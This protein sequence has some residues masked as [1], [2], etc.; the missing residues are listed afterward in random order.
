[1]SKRITIAAISALA[2]LA[3]LIPAGSAQAAF[4]SAPFCGSLNPG[5]GYSPMTLKS[6]QAC[7]FYP[8]AVRYAIAT[9]DVVQGGSGSV[10]LGVVQYPPGYPKGRTLSPTGSGP[11]NYW[12]C[13]PVNGSGG[14][15]YAAWGANNP[16]G[17]VSGQPVLLNF[18]TATIKT[19]LIPGG[20]YSH[21]EYYY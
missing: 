5:G 1:M 13:F 11:G 20:W 12:N 8:V 19:V 16:F 4:G 21:V 3:L 17:A 7:A 15:R 9:W 6:G 10:C 18:S 14:G 2:S